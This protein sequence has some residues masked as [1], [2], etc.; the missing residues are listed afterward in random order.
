MYCVILIIFTYVYKN[1][2][3]TNFRRV[4]IVTKIKP[5]EKLTDEIFNSENFPIYGSL[6]LSGSREHLL[7]WYLC[8]CFVRMFICLQVNN[9]GGMDAK[10]D[11]L[12][13]DKSEL[14]RRGLVGVWVVIATSFIPGTMKD[15]AN[16]VASVLRKTATRLEHNE[17]LL[18]TDSAFH[19]C[20][21][22]PPVD[23]CWDLPLDSPI[24]RQNKR[25][26]CGQLRASLIPTKS[27]WQ[28]VDSHDEA[29]Q[30]IPDGI[31]KV[32]KSFSGRDKMVAT[33]P[34][35]CDPLLS[36]IAAINVSS[37]LACLLLRTAACVS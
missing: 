12:L 29:V 35:V 4:L 19:H 36:K 15:T 33:F 14:C 16:M 28:L 6:T 25:C 7:K 13:C 23:Q 11:E 32:L 20:W 27:S 24:L 22:F 37:D 31:V 2:T 30:I 21:S 8:D 10:L 3:Y 9:F 17:G 1:S 18:L 34:T 5:C 26:N